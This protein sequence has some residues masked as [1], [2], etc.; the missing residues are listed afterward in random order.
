MCSKLTL[1]C[2]IH[3]QLL[4]RLTKKT[5]KTDRRRQ[6]NPM[7]VR[8]FTQ[9]VKPSVSHTAGSQTHRFGMVV[10][11]SVD[12]RLR[13]AVDHQ[14]AIG[15]GNRVP[16]DWQPNALV[17]QFVA[18]RRRHLSPVIQCDPMLDKL[19]SLHILSLAYRS[20]SSNIRH[21]DSPEPTYPHP[22]PYFTVFRCGASGAVFRDTAVLLLL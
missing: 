14:C 11:L 4:D 1:A 16:A 8:G 18:L 12:G 13:C 22:V 21:L 6:R 3:L 15:R 17:P 7:N 2:I 5:L 20:I 19:W 9:T 10:V